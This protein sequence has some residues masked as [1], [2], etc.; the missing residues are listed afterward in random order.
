VPTAP[1][2]CFC[3]A[4]ATDRDCYEIDL[5]DRSGWV[6]DVPTINIYAGSSEL[7][8]LTISL[9]TRTE[10][11]G[12]LSC[13]E[14]ADKNRCEPYAQWVISYVPKNGELTLDGQTSRATLDCNRQ[15]SPA[16][17]VYGRNGAP[18][19]WPVLN[20]AGFCL[21]IETDAFLPPAPDATL[22]LSVSGRAS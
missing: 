4:L 13:E 16:T 17:T 2:S 6:D 18:P 15:C 10:A 22:S 14:L 21:C 7:R 8:R 20:C 9:F 1:E 11:D 3:E 19:T 12:A 5:S